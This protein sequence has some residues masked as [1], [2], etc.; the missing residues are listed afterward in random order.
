MISV[1]TNQ[2]RFEEFGTGAQAVVLVHGLGLNHD[3]WQWQLPAFA[4]HFRVIAYDLYGHGDS[5][6]PPTAPSLALFSRQLCELLD[7]LKIDKVAIIGF[8]LGGMIARRF[9]ID[10]GDRL[11]ALA[12][13]NTAHKRDI[14]DKRA[15]Q[16]R[17]DQARREGPSVTV[18]AALERWFTSEFRQ[19]HPHVMGLVRTWVLAN[20]SAIYP[21]IYQ[22]LVDGVDELVAPDPPIDCP[23]LVMTG[24]K[25]YG[26]SAKMSEAI[27]AEIPDSR[28]VILP[29]L[30]H[31]ALAEAPELVNKEL[32]SF[33]QPIAGAGRS[34][35][36]RSNE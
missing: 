20:D 27:A 8:S 10:Y 19:R 28:L 30:R 6:P 15:I 32:L 3:M 29:G 9:A 22:V 26:N 16:A 14:S 31:M 4:P 33:L 23:T 36:T 17:V 12:L 5:P 34:S 2:T 13:M 1:A 35:V 21:Q 25:D 18:E 11:W 7:D 24:D